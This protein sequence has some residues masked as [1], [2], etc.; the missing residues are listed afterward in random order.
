MRYALAILFFSF[1]SNLNA[2]PLPE[3]ID[4]INLNIG[5]MVRIDLQHF[6]SLT[7]LIFL[8]ARCPCSTS[9]E[10][11]LAQLAK[12]FPKVRFVGIHSNTDEDT[13][14]SRKHFQASQLNFP[15]IQDEHAELAKK[16]GAFKTPHV[17]LYSPN[18]ELLFQGGI[19]NS[20]DAS[21]ATEFYLRDAL[22][23]IHD[24]RPVPRPEVRVLG[25]AI[26]R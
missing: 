6:E 1:A 15:V 8:S 16:L 13:P 5:R 3:K 24:N 10:S 26:K 22:M 9:H 14:L 23:A 12:E 11:G 7:A 21:K 25:C 18:G 20:H 2:A 19:D 4:G 17:Y